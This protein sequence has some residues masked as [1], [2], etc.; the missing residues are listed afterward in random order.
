MKIKSNRL[1]FLSKI[2]W[3]KINTDRVTTIIMLVLISWMSIWFLRFSKNFP[4]GDGYEYVMTAEAVYNHGTPDIKKSDAK[5]YV[6]YLERM[7]E[8]VYL[9]WIYINLIKYIDY[10]EREEI[11]FEKER[12][13]GTTGFILA[14]NG[15]MYAQ[16]FWFYPALTIPARALLELFDAD[17]A[18]SF[19]MTHLCLLYIVV[20]L[21]LTNK[22]LNYPKRVV[23]ATLMCFSPA[24]WYI[25]WP[26]PDFLAGIFT[27]LAIIY[28]FTERKVLAILILSIISFH[29]PPLAF[30]ALFMIFNVLYEQWGSW[31]IKLFLKLFTASIWVFVPVIF[32]LMVF[33]VPSIISHMG[34][35]SWDFVTFHRFWG[36]FFDLNQGAILG[37]PLFIILFIPFMVYDLIKKQHLI[38]YYLSSSIII[39]ALFFMQMT[40]WNHGCEVVNRY[41]VWVSMMLMALFII[42]IFEIKRKT[43]LSSTVVLLVSTQI[44]AISSQANFKKIRWT[45]QIMTPI[46][47]YVLTHYPEVYNPD[48]KI[49]F[50][51]TKY[52]TNSRTDSVLVFADTD[53]VITKFMVDTS[54]YEQLIQRGMEAVAVKDFMQEA[55]LYHNRWFYVNKSDFEKLGYEQSSDTMI[56]HINRKKK[57]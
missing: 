26:H 7:N 3:S 55:R 38:I 10:I 4:N 19:L 18:K 56:Q 50:E 36:F 28:F 41:A 16:H 9:K 6:K 21:I 42:R 15:K 40:N 29:F 5:G 49:F 47:K 52:E 1:N 32:N 23:L 44:F 51:R 45:A 13:N 57:E 46:S 2:K 54:A 34:Y 30:V 20:W 11:T 31:N 27:F 24:I 17:I 48:P 33:E 53:S 43:L 8:E 25:Q 12:I 37:I 14:N 39:M 35:L 22:K